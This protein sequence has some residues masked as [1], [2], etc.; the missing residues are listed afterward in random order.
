[1]RQAVQIVRMTI[2]ARLD[3]GVR[4]HLAEG[5]DEAFFEFRVLPKRVWSECDQSPCIV[6]VVR[7][8]AVLGGGPTAGGLRGPL[9]FTPNPEGESSWKLMD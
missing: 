5:G 8:D 3:A 4:A 6:Q 7:T 9:P 2:I 1:M